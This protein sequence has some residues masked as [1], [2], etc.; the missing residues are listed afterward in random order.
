VNQN[1]EE[2]YNT[3]VLIP[4][5]F[6]CMSLNRKPV[7]AVYCRTAIKIPGMEVSIIEGLSVD[8]IPGPNR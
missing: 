2:I 5:N 1:Q 6:I 7:S 4:F 8:G 3:N